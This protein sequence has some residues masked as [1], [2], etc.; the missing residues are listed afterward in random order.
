MPC[1]RA[2]THTHMWTAAKLPVHVASIWHGLGLTVLLSEAAQVAWKPLFNAT[3]IA[4]GSASSA[5]RLTR[6]ISGLLTTGLGD[7]VWV[8]FRDRKSVV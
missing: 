4:I 2:S 3:L 1:H 6:G 7:A 5:F 8:T